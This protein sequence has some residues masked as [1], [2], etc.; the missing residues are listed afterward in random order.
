[1]RKIVTACVLSVVLFGDEIERINA[2]VREI[3]NLR[4]GFEQCQRE[5]IVCKKQKSTTTDDTRLQEC[6]DSLHKLSQSS[7]AES[8]KLN[9]QIENLKNQIKKQKNSLKIKSKEIEKLKKE[10]NNL[11]KYK[12]SKNT[13]LKNQINKKV[14]KIDK[15][16]QKRC[17]APAVIIKEKQKQTRIALDKEGRVV[18]QESYKITTTRPKTFRTLREALIYDKPGGVRIDLWEKGRSFT[19]YIESGNWIKI[20]GYFINKKWTKT[21]REMWIKKSD[22]Y[23]R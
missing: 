9:K 16:S 8:Q 10:L 20:T 21:K 2:L 23:E 18:I 13:N 5:L 6:E 11:K 19:S 17:P 14:K 4:T 12:F 1:M 3:A 15:T 7:I 22:A